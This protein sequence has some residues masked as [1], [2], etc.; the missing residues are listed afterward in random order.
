[1]KA[2]QNNKNPKPTMGPFLHV[3]SRNCRGFAVNTRKEA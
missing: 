1:M 2:K 3:L